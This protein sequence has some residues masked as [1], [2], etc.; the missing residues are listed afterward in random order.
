M[1]YHMLNVMEIIINKQTNQK[2]G[3]TVSPGSVNGVSHIFQAFTRY[4]I[5]YVAHFHQ[6]HSDQILL[7]YSNSRVCTLCYAIIL[8]MCFA[9]TLQYIF[10]CPAS[11]YFYSNSQLFSSTLSCLNIFYSILSFLSDY[12]HSVNLFKSFSN[13]SINSRSEQLSKSITV[14]SN[15][16]LTSMHIF[17]SFQSTNCF[18]HIP[19]FF[20]SLQNSAILIEVMSND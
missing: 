8:E 17:Y 16:H 13:L 5:S 4:T 9:H 19:M 11:S 20:F 2:R 7:Y 10:C 6:M 12:P 14:T 18:S 15:G 3:A 1:W